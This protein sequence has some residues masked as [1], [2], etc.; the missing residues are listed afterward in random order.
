MFLGVDGLIVC[1]EVCV[2][3]KNLIFMLI[4]CIDDMDQVLG[5]EMGVDD[6]VVK[7][8]K[9]CVLLVC[10]CVLLWWVEI[11]SECDSLLLWLEFGVLV[12]DNFV[13]E[14]SLCGKL[15][16]LISVE[17]DLFWLLVFNVGM[18]LFCEIIF[19]KLC[20][21]Q[22]DGQDCFIDVCIFCIWFKVGDDLENFK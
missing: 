10:I 8:V 14:V 19:E 2:I 15:V 22:Y 6:Y 17:Y 4:V 9:L 16:D 3:F 7:L 12:I 21:I 18:V 1:W 11:D 5:L 13:R 20:G